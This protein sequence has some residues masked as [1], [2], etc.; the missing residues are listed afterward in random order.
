MKIFDQPFVRDIAQDI[1]DQQMRTKY[2][3]I[4]QAILREA[5]QGNFSIIFKKEKMPLECL[6]WL[7]DKGF[8]LYTDRGNNDEWFEFEDM[9]GAFNAKRIK[10]VW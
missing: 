10:V 9:D 6:Y 7:K 8:E 3:P 4:L 2:T 1:Y 5:E